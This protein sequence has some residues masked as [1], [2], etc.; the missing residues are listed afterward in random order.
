MGYLPAF[1][2]MIGVPI[3]TFLAG[4]FLSAVNGTVTA[5]NEK[6]TLRYMNREKE[7]L[8]KDISEIRWEIYTEYAGRYSTKRIRIVIIMVDE[9]SFDPDFDPDEDDP[10]QFILNDKITLEQL[11]SYQ[12][13]RQQFILND[14][15]TMEK[16]ASCQKGRHRDIPLLRIY[17]FIA[18]RIPERALGYVENKDGIFG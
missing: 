5:D 16:L 12:G 8:I 13:S 6:I 17:N 4:E 18:G 9:K 1:C 2:F 11:A 15:I 3:V 7:I 10:D 14:N